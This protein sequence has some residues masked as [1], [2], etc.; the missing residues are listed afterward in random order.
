MGDSHVWVLP[1]SSFGTERRQALLSGW[2]S[3]RYRER[4]FELSPYSYKQKVDD[5]TDRLQKIERK[6]GAMMF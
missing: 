2:R 4:G 6:L 3:K 5:L 1:G